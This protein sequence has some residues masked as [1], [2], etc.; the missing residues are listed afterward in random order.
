[1]RT[2]CKGFVFKG[3]LTLV[4]VLLASRVAS[5]AVTSIDVDPNADLNPQRTEATING[6]IGCDSAETVAVLI[7]VIQTA[8][9]LLN[10]GIFSGTATCV[11]QGGGNFLG[12]F[13]I[14]VP[15]ID[16]LKYRPGPATVVVKATDATNDYEKG[17]KTKLLP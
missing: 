3:V 4:V 11:D 14:V 9:R 1:M 2:I 15:A 13:S 6:S 16:G 12:G 5:A 10:I 17:F 8:G 7:Y